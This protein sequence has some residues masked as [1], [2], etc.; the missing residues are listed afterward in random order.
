MPDQTGA[1]TEQLI[2]RWNEL[3]PEERLE[4]FQQIPRDH[5]DDFFLNLTG[6]DQTMLIL[7]LP[8]GQRRLWMRLL[9]PD[10]AADVIQEAPEEDRARLLGLLDDSSRREVSALLAYAEDAAGGLMSPRFAR[11]RPEMTVNEAITYLRKQAGLVET[12]HFAYVLDT[13]QHLLGIVTFRHLLSAAPEKTVREIMRTERRTRPKT[14]TRKPLPNCS[15][16][17][18]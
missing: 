3:S 15:P 11:A 5:A 4:A 1:A 6:R 7:S 8:D 2:D 17:S 16:K 9:A 18:T 10:D 14:W 13:E 12:I